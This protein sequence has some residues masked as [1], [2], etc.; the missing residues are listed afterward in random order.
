MS[1]KIERLM[2]RQGRVVAVSSLF[3]LGIY[4]GRLSM[5]FAWLET[6]CLAI[7]MINV[8]MWTLPIIHE[9]RREQRE[10]EAVI[11]AVEDEMR[12]SKG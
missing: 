4:V 8:L 2:R 7:W 5:K 6:L 11:K 9:A 12:G 10:L 1:I 3:M